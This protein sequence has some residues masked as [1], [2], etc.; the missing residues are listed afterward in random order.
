MY[1]IHKSYI[2]RKT[3]FSQIYHSITGQFAPLPLTHQG[4]EGVWQGYVMAI[5]PMAYITCTFSIW[6]VHV[7]SHSVHFAGECYYWLIDNNWCTCICK[8]SEGLTHVL[9]RGRKLDSVSKCNSVISLFL[10]YVSFKMCGQ[11]IRLTD[12]INMNYILQETGSI[13]GYIMREINN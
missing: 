6:S 2:R 8:Y 7:E 3:F 1:L 9:V 4:A 5:W 11:I 12:E 13:L 10:R